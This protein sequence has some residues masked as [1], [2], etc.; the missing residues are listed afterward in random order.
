MKVLN[1]INDRVVVERDAAEEKKGEIYL[2]ESA[3]EKPRTGTV[4]AIGRGR[5]CDNGT[6]VPP[7]VAV[8]ER[9]VFAKHGG[10]EVEVEGKK[11]LILKED[12]LYAVV[13]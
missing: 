4:V 13:D 7:S 2:A 12:D 1:P 8:G 9:V 6:L 3:Q 11:L 10:S 5:V